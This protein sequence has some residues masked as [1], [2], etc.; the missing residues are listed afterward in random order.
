[1][2]FTPFVVKRF[3]SRQSGA[4]ILEYIIYTVLALGVFAGIAV[5]AVNANTNSNALGLTK[6]L[7][8]TQIAVKNFYNGTGYGTGSLNAAL[9][10]AGTVLP[11]DWILSTPNIQS[12]SNTAIVITGATTT[13]TLA[14]SKLSR[15][16]CQQI[17]ASSSGAQWSSVTIGAT[18]P[19]TITTW[20]I[21]QSAVSTPCAAGN[22]T[23][24]F[25]SQ[26]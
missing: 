22:V 26:A 13:F 14:V 7:T 10:T 21:S 17:V 25:T 4:T 2:K 1:M 6:N 23:V 15:A 9:I 16:I 3:K 5:F 24:T 12:Q 8:G 20:P 19:I 11:S 18:T